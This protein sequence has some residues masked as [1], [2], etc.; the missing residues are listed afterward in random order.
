MIYSVSIHDYTSAHSETY[1]F[2]KLKDAVAF[3]KSMKK[4][5]KNTYFCLYFQVK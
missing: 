4:V 3:L 2:P 1:H 5:R